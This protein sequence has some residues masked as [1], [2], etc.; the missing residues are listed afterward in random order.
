MDI[1]YNIEKIRQL[2]PINIVMIDNKY[3]IKS[4]G[5]HRSYYLLLC[6]LLEISKCQS[7]EKIEQ[8]NRKYTFSYNVSKKS[9]SEILNMISYAMIKCKL[10][11]LKVLFIDNLTGLI[12]IQLN[13]K[14][15]D[16]YNDNELINLMEIYLQESY[17]PK[18]INVLNTIGF[19][20]RINLNLEEN[21]SSHKM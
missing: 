19:F 2:E 3:Y 17:N 8:I 20:E 12:K 13:G 16:V 21:I 5:N 9:N 7:P 18:L 15:F 6:Y 10:E 14:E 1:D 11:D 4:D